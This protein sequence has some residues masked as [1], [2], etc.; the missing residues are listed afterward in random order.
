M[1]KTDNYIIDLHNKDVEIQ[2][3]KK[4]IEELKEDKKAIKSFTYDLVN[5]LEENDYNFE[6]ISPEEIDNYIAWI[7]NYCD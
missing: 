6:L 2:Q 5:Y 3:L 7:Q 1:S 4:E